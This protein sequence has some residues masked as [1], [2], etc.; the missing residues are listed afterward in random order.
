MHRLLER[1]FKKIF[2]DASPRSPEVVALLKAVS[3][4]YDTY[5][6][7][8]NFI[9][10]SF[11][12]SSKEFSV[13]HDNVLK[14]LKELRS[15]KESVEKKV[16]ERTKELTLANKRLLELDKVKTEFISVAAHQLRTPLTAI[17][18]AFN[19]LSPKNAITPPSEEQRRTIELGKGAADNMTLIVNDLL[20]VAR[21]SGGTFQFSIEPGDVRDAVRASGNLFEE[22]ARSKN[23]RLIFEVPAVPLPAKFDRGNLALAIEN[24]IDNAI[25]YTP[26]GGSVS[27]RA[28]RE[29]DKI[30]ITVSDTGIGI[31]RDEQARLFEK[32]F[33]GKSAARMFTDGSGL[34][35]FIAKNIVEGHGGTI[36]LVSGEN[37]GTDA[38]I[39]LPVSTQ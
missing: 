30:H 39:V 2:H 6:S 8:H 37:G 12:I 28:T 20:N 22:I 21:I 1:Q 14:L 13:L 27:V 32:F 9:E 5:D 38:T 17:R 35:L 4:T 15:E 29:G 36:V 26:N 24:L 19:S 16:V 7:D 33:R 25:K 10:R 3:D 31:S 23:I 11:D 34:G 18:W